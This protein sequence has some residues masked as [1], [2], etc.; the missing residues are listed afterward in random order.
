MGECLVIL[1]NS[2]FPFSSKVFS[3]FNAV[4][5]EYPKI[6]NVKEFSLEVRF[7]SPNLL[8]VFNVKLLTLAPN[9][10]FF[11]VS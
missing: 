11:P 6:P 4:D 10:A 2:R 8:V 1:S 9:K 3:R 7:L 5:W